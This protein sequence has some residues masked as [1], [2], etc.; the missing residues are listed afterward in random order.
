MTRQANISCTLCGQSIH[1]VTESIPG[2]QQ[3]QTYVIYEC[4]GCL[5]SFASPLKVEDSI[6][7]LIYKNIQQ[8]P[9]YNRYYQYAHDVLKQMKALDFLSRQEE[10]YWAVAQHLQKRKNAGDILK[11]LEVGC[12][13]GYF[14]YALAQDGFEITGVDVA[15]E[16]VAWAIEHY[17]PY[18]ANK[19]LQELK[20]RGDS[21][22]TIIMNQL[23]EHLP[24]VHA[25]V[26]D[27][28]ALLAPGG[29]LILTTPNKSAY[30]DAKWETELPPVHLW[31]FGEHAMRYLA[32][33][34]ACSITFIDFEPFYNF[35]FRIKTSGTPMSSRGPVFDTQGRLL[36]DQ[37]TP[38]ESRFR[39]VLEQV[40]ILS[41][42]R[43]IK[44]ITFNK[45]RWQGSRGPICACILRRP[46]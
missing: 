37:S 4:E 7:G 23:I 3:G 17:G 41:A 46:R 31:W 44:A 13:M 28:L 45:Y 2:Y 20:E 38:M 25:F 18:Y 26:S 8:V 43:G 5:S 16:A 30:P 32:D 27:A 12:G 29:E 33:R 15:P 6:Y 10:S 39:S 42:Y 21:Y 35:F 11:I 40:G 14:S 19:T 22:D 1:V 36:A 9:G 24:D 34:Y